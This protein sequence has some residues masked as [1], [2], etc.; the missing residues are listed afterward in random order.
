MKKRDGYLD[1]DVM[2]VD[3]Q[4]VR[5]PEKTTNGGLEASYGYRKRLRTPWGAYET[6]T[7]FSVPSLYGERERYAQVHRPVSNPGV[8]LSTFKLTDS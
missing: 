8:A 3:G 5:V 7:V 1:D 4:R 2:I 6:C